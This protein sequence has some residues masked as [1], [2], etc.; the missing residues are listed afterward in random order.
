MLYQILALCLVVISFCEAE[1]DFGAAER[2][3]FNSELLE[4][5]ELWKTQH[6][7]SYGH[8][9]EELERHLIWASNRKYIEEHN[10]NADLFGYTLAMN[11]FGD[12]VR[13]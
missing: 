7:K 5:W 1:G 10:A 8:K 6:G 13:W 9:V 11:H 12:L 3:G 4:E 2:A